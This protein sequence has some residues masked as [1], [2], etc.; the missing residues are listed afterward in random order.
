MSKKI[1]VLGA[2]NGGYVMAADLTMGGHKVNFYEL[3]EYAAKNLGPVI[4]RGGIEVISQDNS[5]NEIELSAGGR[6]GFAKILGTIGS[7]IQETIFGVDIIMLVVPGFVREK[8]IRAF[9]P[10]LEDGQII[11]IWPGYFG[12]LQCAKLLKDLGIEKDIAI[13]ETES[14]FYNC[15]KLGGGKVRNKGEKNKILVSAFPD[16]KKKDTIAE[17]K[18]IFPMFVPARNVLETTLANINP[19]LHPES[20][21]LNLY[22]VERK[23]YPFDEK[24]N[25]PVLKAYDLTPGMARLVK[26]I[27]L[28]RQALGNKFGLKINSLK[29]TLEVW[30]DAKGKDLYETITN[31]YAY[32]VQGAP[33]SLEERYVT[34]DI[35]YSL[36]PYTLLG[37][38]IGVPVDT[39]RAMA[40]IGCAITGHD[41]WKSGLN[42]E[43]IGLS[44]KSIPEI[45]DF[46][47]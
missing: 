17:L 4:D 3:P 6:S 7:D 16:K 34:E 26:Q 46:L 9:A 24:M 1:A 2:G 47:G 37:E 32:Q 18:K 43:A 29:E 30:Y 14:L 38:Q 12:A 42:M 19:T 11:V 41:F 35:P 8:F 40:T 15:S 33:I 5:G 25:K 27:D 20:V 44:G 22:R 13:A 39:I 21:L 10:Y 23:F 31:C 45:I 28:E 36:V